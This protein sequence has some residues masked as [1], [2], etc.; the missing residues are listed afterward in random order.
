MS[1]SLKKIRTST[2]A[3]MKQAGEKFA[4]LTSYDSLT[5][6]IFDEAGIEVILVGDSAGN[7]VLGHENTLE[8]TIDE[9][10][11]FGRAVATAAKHSLVVM[12]M[13]FGSYEVSAE[14]AVESAIKLMKQT[15]ASAVKLEGGSNRVSQIQAIVAA[16]IPVMGHL[17][18]TPQSVHAIGGFK[19]QGRGESANELIEQAKQLESAGVF[20]LVLEMVPSS[21]AEVITK[22]LDIPTI[23]IG[24]GN[25]T[26][27]QIL[28]WQDFAG[29]SIGSRKFV[30]KYADLGKDL[31]DAARSFRADVQT[32]SFPGKEHSFED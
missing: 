14:K 10:I 20:S 29:L 24:A 3:S 25:Q 9:M 6:G 30:K 22:D 12:D 17:G 15:G 23:G 26:D 2:L 7:T 11:S 4:C 31:A 13:P 27:G 8:V 16:G 32:S 19:V 1:T 5:A 18:F 21:V 28:V